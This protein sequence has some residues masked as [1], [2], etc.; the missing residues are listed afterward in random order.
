MAP[1]WFNV[2]TKE[3]IDRYNESMNKEDTMMI[4]SR[5]QKWIT[6]TP[7]SK[8]RKYPLEKIKVADMD[9]TS[10]IMPNWMQIRHDQIGKLKK[11]NMKPVTYNPIREVNTLI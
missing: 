9:K 8:N 4:F 5:Y 11:I 3:K 1:E 10:R 6:V 2:V 7:K